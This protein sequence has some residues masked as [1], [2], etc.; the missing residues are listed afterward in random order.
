MYQRSDEKTGMASKTARKLQFGDHL[1]LMFPIYSWDENSDYDGEY[2][3][4][5]INWGFNTKFNEVPLEDGDYYYMFVIEDI[6][7]NKHYSDT[8]IIEVDGDSIWCYETE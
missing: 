6:F 8:A 2:I 3:L 7:G 1:E 5:E 4:G